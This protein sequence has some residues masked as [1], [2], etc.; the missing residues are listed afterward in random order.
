MRNQSERDRV[1][2]RIVE[3]QLREMTKDRDSFKDKFMTACDQLSET[4]DKLDNLKY[5]YNQL[6]ASY[7]EYI[8]KNSRIQMQLEDYRSKLVN[9]AE[10]FKE[11]IKKE[12]DLKEWEKELRQIRKRTSPFEYVDFND[13]YV[14][15]QNPVKDRGWNTDEVAIE[16]IIKPK[17]NTKINTRSSFADTV[18]SVLGGIPAVTE[19]ITE[20]DIV[21]PTEHTNSKLKAFPV[22]LKT[23]PQSSQLIGNT[24][25]YNIKNGIIEEENDP[26]NL[27]PFSTRSKDQFRTASSIPFNNFNSPS[28][29]R[30]TALQRH[31]KAFKSHYESNL[32]DEPTYSNV[33]IEQR[34]RTAWSITKEREHKHSHKTAMKSVYSH[35]ISDPKIRPMSG[36][37]VARRSKHIVLSRKENSESTFVKSRPISQD[38]TMSK[39]QIQIC[40]K[41]Q[42][43]RPKTSLR[44]LIKVA[45]TRNGN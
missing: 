18:T 28:A 14:Q 44:N 2:R 3:K 10:K 40:S 13:K 36:Q 45:S 31:Q 23:R 29:S 39:T 35:S 24:Y 5:D 21:S 26:L 20:I 17:K 32:K 34:V 42:G 7:D 30:P 12:K 15:T 27:N 1:D 22:H 43:G 9:N 16:Y 25:S 41:V 37:P 4:K 33:F 6:K 11:L 38:P 8:I 19:T